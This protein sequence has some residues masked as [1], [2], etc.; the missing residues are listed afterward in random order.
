MRSTKVLPGVNAIVKLNSALDGMNGQGE[1]LISVL[2]GLLGP[3]KEHGFYEV[4]KHWKL[5][6]NSC[7][8]LFP[9]V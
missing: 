9:E 3:R 2:L 7:K 6:Q 8:S 1:T 5:V 4:Y